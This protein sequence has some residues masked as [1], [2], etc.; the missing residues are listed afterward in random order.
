MLS[1]LRVLRTFA[2]P[3]LV[4]PFAMAWLIAPLAHPAVAEAASWTPGP[5]MGSARSGAT[6]LLMADGAVLQMGGYVFEGNTQTFLNSAERYDPLSRTWHATSTMRVA[7]A[8]GQAA[9]L[10]DG[11]VL[12]M[13]GYNSAGYVPPQLYDPTTDSWAFTLAPP[14]NQSYWV[15]SLPG[16][17]AMAGYEHDTITFDPDTGGW[18]DG[19]APGVSHGSGAIAVPLSGGRFVLYGGFPASVGAPTGATEMYDPAT[20]WTT[21][22]TWTRPRV[23]SHPVALTDGR[24]LVVGGG[25]GHAGKADL[26]DPVTGAWTAAPDPHYVHN[27]QDSASPLRADRGFAQA[28]GHYGEVFDGA[29]NS[30]HDAGLG[31]AYRD[32]AT[33]MPLPNG[34]VLIAGGVASNAVATTELFVPAPS[35][36][37]LV[38]A[39]IE[40]AVVSGSVAIGATEDEA[41]TIRFF[42]GGVLV[43]TEPASSAGQA[44]GSLSTYGLAN[45]P[46]TITAQACTVGGCG[47]LSQARHVTLSNSAP[48][49]STPVTG[50]T[51][52]GNITLAANAV[53]GGVRFLV[54]G[55]QRGFDADAPYTAVLNTYAL[56]QGEH[57]VVAASCRADGSVCNGPQSS[58]VSFTVDHRPVVT[59]PSPGTVAGITPISVSGNGSS[60]RVLVDGVA[61]P[62]SPVA[63]HAGVAQIN[64][65]TYGLAN[66]SHVVTAQNCDLVYGCLEPSSDLALNV[67]NDKPA[68]TSPAESAGLGSVSVVAVQAPGG[69]VRVEL[70][71][72]LIGTDSSAPYEVT[73]DPGAHAAGAH[74]LVARSCDMDGSTCNGPASDVVHITTEQHPGISAPLAGDSVTGVVTLKASSLAPKVRFAIDGTPVGSN[75]A[76]AGGVAQTTWSSFGHA[77]GPITI[78]A[79]GCDGSCG[80]SFSSVQAS[81][82]NAAPVITSPPQGARVGDTAQVAVAAAP[83]QAI[84]L[85]VDGTQVGLDST[86]PYSFTWDADAWGA[87]THSL[88]AVACSADGLVCDGPQSDARSVNVVRLHP[89]HGAITNQYFSPNADGI[90]DTTSVPVVIDE[91][92]TVRASIRN[93]SGSEV[94]AKSYG[95]RAAGSFAV[96][97]NGKTSAGAVLGNGAYAFTLEE[98]KLA[99]GGYLTG[100]T[101]ALLYL[102]RSAPGLS[103]ATDSGALYPISD[104]Y[105]D[106]F[107]AVINSSERGTGILRI[108]NSANRLVFSKAATFASGRNSLG[109]NGRIGSGIAAAGTYHYAFQVTDA[110]GNKRLSASRT[111]AVSHKRL[112]GHAARATVTPAGSLVQ[113]LVGSC[114]RVRT[115]SVDF[116]AGGYD[117]LSEYYCADYY[118]DGSGLAATRHKFTL[119]AAVKYSGIRV[120]VTGM[121]DLPGWG[122]VGVLLYE[123]RYGSTT[124]TGGVVAGSAYGTY[125]APSASTSWLVN[126]RTIHWL[127]GTTDGDYYEVKSF[128]VSYTYYTLQ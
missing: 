45:G 13:G 10:S 36:P 100:Q 37:P 79:Y 62:G 124:G 48:T 117:Y 113:Q 101:T 72:E 34:S 108:Y 104:G 126:G 115:P 63:P 31:N 68:I 19:P 46:M 112:V 43:D 127:F 61:L 107:A 103:G 39:P 122:D 23:A 24:I 110:A 97:W 18:Q 29:T 86:A 119:P 118:G 78:T 128:T 77:N 57:V 30:W 88:G 84:A 91:V 9:L 59:S 123:D 51:I 93:S 116:G 105:R 106:A 6:P 1:C 73:L 22:S 54:D 2:A 92:S 32:Y 102:D 56:S 83:G 14:A 94:W 99:Y 114:S 85:Y 69:T 12:V 60:V 74:T 111:F 33:T 17:K 5:S 26:L 109:W 66:G 21:W 38:T 81:V 125:T 96:A 65:N 52:D 53:G 50:Q 25:N 4:A 98:K 121:E 71:G 7:F 20:G 82:A 55:T 95:T 67:N 58:A 28:A 35:G 41:A 87:G 75:V 15:V 11:R 80:S 70:D 89:G 3:L 90:R 8:F 76:V 44:I 64:W 47:P 120:G 27:P 40:G 16:G 49:V 42:S